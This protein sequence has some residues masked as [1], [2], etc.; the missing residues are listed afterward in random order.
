MT[1]MAYINL[2]AH[3]FYRT[4]DASKTSSFFKKNK[5]RKMGAPLVDDTM[6]DLKCAHFEILH[7]LYIVQKKE[8]KRL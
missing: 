2:I 8:G 4:F 6:M 5:C 1:Q 7:I 3:A